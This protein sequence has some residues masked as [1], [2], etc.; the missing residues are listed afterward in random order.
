MFIIIGYFKSILIP[1]YS[2]S[3]SHRQSEAAS[4]IHFMDFLDDVGG[5]VLSIMFIYDLCNLI[6]GCAFEETPDGKVTVSFEDLLIFFT[7]AEREPP[8]GFPKE[9]KLLFLHQRNEQLATASTCDLILRIPTCHDQYVDF[10]NKMVM[11]LT[12]HGGFGIL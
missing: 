4:Y 7:G 12:S 10:K 8:L 9:G 3:A 5:E 1:Q 6:D 2:N 11:S